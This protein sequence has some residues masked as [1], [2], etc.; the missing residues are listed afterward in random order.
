MARDGA[1]RYSGS[2]VQ[3]PKKEPIS[4]YLRQL[5][6]GRESFARTTFP[7]K[8]A[9]S[10][11][12]EPRSTFLPAVTA[13]IRNRARRTET[14]AQENKGPTFRNTEQDAEAEIREDRNE[15]RFSSIIPKIEKSDG[16]RIVGRV[17]GR[18][19]Y[20]R[21]TSDFRGE[22]CSWRALHRSACR[23]P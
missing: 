5:V 1:R 22:D 7:L 21:F 18:T 2:I 6:L 12:V 11:P 17:L 4:L 19:L 14:T 20:E 10:H 8:K 15:T 23:E 16:S 9:C 3:T 13:L